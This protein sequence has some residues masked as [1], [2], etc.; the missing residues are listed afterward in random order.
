VRYGSRPWKDTDTSLSD[1][2]CGFSAYKEVVVE[3]KVVGSDKP[4]RTTLT[5]NC[6]GKCWK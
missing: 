6:A 5:T 1:E 4:E 2:E 3:V